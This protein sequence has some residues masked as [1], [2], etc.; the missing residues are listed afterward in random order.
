[1]KK[2]VTAVSRLYNK[3]MNKWEVPKNRVVPKKHVVTLLPVDEQGRGGWSGEVDLP[4]AK[5]ELLDDVCQA[6]RTIAREFPEVSIRVNHFA[7]KSRVTRHC[8]LTDDLD[9]LSFDIVQGEQRLDRATAD[10]LCTRLVCAL[11]EYG[12]EQIDR[13]KQ[14]QIQVECEH[15]LRTAFYQDFDMRVA[16]QDKQECDLIRVIDDPDDERRNID[17]LIELLVAKHESLMGID[18][19]DGPPEA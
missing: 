3:L 17:R 5:A 10:A 12:I 4:A 19:E 8:V 9:V 11:G 18:A 1:M 2:Q 7:G 14:R 16:P 13:L 6:W 15:Q